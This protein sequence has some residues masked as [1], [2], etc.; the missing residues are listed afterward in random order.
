MRKE[1]K[2]TA[3]ASLS[4]MIGFSIIILLAYCILIFIYVAPVVN[5]DD[6][7]WIHHAILIIFSGI[8]PTLAIYFTRRWF[9]VITLKHSGIKVRYL[10]V[11]PIKKFSWTEIME[12]RYIEWGGKW[13]LFSKSL[14]TVNDYKSIIKQKDVIQI[15]YKEK[16]VKVIQCYY[17]KKIV[18]LPKK[19]D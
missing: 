8:L 12:I 17:Y 7:Q 2:V 16:V 19:L 5:I 3:L 1:Q 13:L 14:F 11:V 4:M 10:G 18:G 9:Y 15:A 6:F